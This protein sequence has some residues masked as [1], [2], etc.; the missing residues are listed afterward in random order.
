[1][2]LET[3]SVWYP[4]AASTGVLIARGRLNATDRLLVHAAGDI[5]TV[6]VY[7]EAGALIAHGTDLPRT[8]ESPV[9]LLTRDGD[10]IFREDLWPTYAHL[11][12]PILLPGG[13]VGILKSWWNAD[14]RKE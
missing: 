9:C 3:W 6:E 8:L 4:K 12:L 7:D 11:G 2:A 13:E 5:I 14:D 1:M 10:S